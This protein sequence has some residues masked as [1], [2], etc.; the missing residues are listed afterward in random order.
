MTVYRWHSV[1]WV[2]SVSGRA[3]CIYGIV[4]G[5][6]HLNNHFKISAILLF[7]NFLL[8]VVADRQMSIASLLD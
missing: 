4:S 2:G 8:P 5:W 7:Q 3:V 1:S 6:L